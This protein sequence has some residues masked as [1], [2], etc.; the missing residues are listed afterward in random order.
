MYKFAVLFGAL[1]LAQIALSNDEGTIYTFSAK[2][3]DGNEVSLDK[4]RLVLKLMKIFIYLCLAAR[5]WSLLMLHRNVV[6]PKRI[7]FN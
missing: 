5:L 1:F 7:M 3:S 4:Y 6:W 2:D